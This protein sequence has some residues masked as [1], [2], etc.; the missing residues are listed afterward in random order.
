MKVLVDTNVLLDVALRRAHFF[1]ASD[2]VVRWREDHPGR[3]F[4]AWHTLS[5]IYYILR[6]ANGE[7]PARGF[8]AD[9]LDHLEVA[10]TGT[11]EAKHALHLRTRD[12]EDALQISA[13]LAAGA[14]AIVTRDPAGFSGSI[15]PVLTPEAFLASA[16][17]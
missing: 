11:P 3:G 13:A 10:P 7:A 5:N 12:Y 16:P 8:I 15:V 9:T 4:V 17:S 14:D 1:A 2:R 6:K